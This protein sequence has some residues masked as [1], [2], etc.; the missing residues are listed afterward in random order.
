MKKSKMTRAYNDAD[1]VVNIEYVKNG[2]ACNCTCVGCG[3][4]VIA[5]QGELQGKKQ[6]NH[7]SHK[8]GDPKASSCTWSYKTDLYLIA[9]EVLL[10][11]K[12]LPVTFGINAPYV[13]NIKFDSITDKASSTIKE[14]TIRPDLVAIVSGETIYIEISV[15]SFCNQQKIAEYRHLELNAIEVY[16]EEFRPESD[17]VSYSEV[18]DYISKAEKNG[19]ILSR[20]AI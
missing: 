4:K 10:E 17:I 2:S 19:L 16:L 9:K 6:A 3:A 12:C 5:K 1:V 18:E 8:P 11:T 14:S 15:S 20:Q 13:M 7:F